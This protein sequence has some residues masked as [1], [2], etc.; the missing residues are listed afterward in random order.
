M[1]EEKI[2]QGGAEMI[3]GNQRRKEY[4]LKYLTSYNTSTVQNCTYSVAG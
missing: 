2:K 3:V 4:L 1:R